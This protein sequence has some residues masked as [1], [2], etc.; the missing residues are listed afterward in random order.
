[1]YPYR[2][3]ISGREGRAVQVNGEYFRLH[4]FTDDGAVVEGVPLVFHDGH[5]RLR[6]D[7]PVEEGPVQSDEPGLSAQVRCRRAPGAGCSRSMEYSPALTEAMRGHHARG[8]TEAAARQRGIVRDQLRH[9]WFV[10]VTGNRRRHYLR[11][12]QPIGEHVTVRYFPVKLHRLGGCTRLSVHLPHR[13]PAVVD[14]VR[15]PATSGPD[16]MTQGEFNIQFRSFASA[17]ASHVYEHAIRAAPNVNLSQPERAAILRYYGEGETSLD[18]YLHGDE[19]PPYR[20]QELGAYAAELDRALLRVPGYA[21]RVYR[22]AMLPS[23]V[24]DSLEVGQM[25]RIPGFVRA[26]GERAIGLHQLEGRE[27]PAGQ[28]PVILE[29]QMR[30]GAHPVGLQTLRDESE[31]IVQRGRVFKVVRN[32][33]GV[34]GLQEAGRARQ[35]FG[36]GGAVNLRLG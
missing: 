33:N 21:G 11:F 15:S 7:D 32:D 19:Q 29:L 9:G 35:A 17:D 14:I 3:T 1:M 27:V 5:Y 6:V 4:A 20:R 28:T 12:E 10:R 34:L 26:S 22:G 18:A 16:L 25:V 30:G 8:L 2:D 13:G 31:V 24:L 23:D 36:P